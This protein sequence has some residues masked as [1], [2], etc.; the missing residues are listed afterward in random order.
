MAGTR[1]LINATFVTEFFLLVLLALYFGL[2][3]T[4]DPISHH[5]PQYQRGR[6]L[7]QAALLELEQQTPSSLSLPSLQIVTTSQEELEKLVGVTKKLPSGVSLTVHPD[8]TK[9]CLQV[10][11]S[12]YSEEQHLSMIGLPEGRNLVLCPSLQAKTHAMII[13]QGITFLYP[14]NPHK[15]LSLVEDVLQSS[16]ATTT[17]TVTTTAP[18]ATAPAATLKFTKRQPLKLTLMMEHHRLDWA[19]WADALSNWIQTKEQVLLAWPC[20]NEMETQVVLSTLMMEKETDTKPASSNA[21]MRI[22][23]TVDMKRAVIDRLASKEVWNVVLYVPRTTPAFFVDS[24]DN[25]NNNNNNSNAMLLDSTLI[26]TI[27]QPESFTK[28]HTKT[29]LINDEDGNPITAAD[30]TYERVTV[31]LETLVAQAMAPLGQFLLQQCLGVTPATSSD[32]AISV[33]T[34]GSVPQWQIEAWTNEKLQETY[35]QVRTQIRQEGEWLLQSSTWVVI[36]ESVA[37]HWQTLVKWMQE[38]VTKTK[39]DI[40]SSYATRLEALSI[41]EEALDYLQVLRTEPT[42][43]EPLRFSLPQFLAIFAPIGLP[44]FLPHSIGLIREWRRYKKLQTA[45]GF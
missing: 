3:R 39:R 34:D 44:L 27:G 20:I 33:D 15:I 23:S 28:E 13:R 19:E 43:M 16:P 6:P 36:D 45:K 25:N 21:T 14:N 12:M 24:I 30:T 41:L 7:L 35:Q 42:L 9:T 8:I 37:E 18:A 22:L 4:K 1:L 10:A 26:I 32:G 31:P 2:Y 17:T 29:K 40:H 11:T 38:V 5:L